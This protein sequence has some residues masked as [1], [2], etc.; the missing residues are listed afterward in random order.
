[1]RDPKRIPEML[2]VVKDI[3]TKYPDLRL[4]QLILNTIFEGES[5][6]YVEDKKLLERLKNVYGIK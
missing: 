4:T 6:Y 3:W 1:M 5:A 2:D